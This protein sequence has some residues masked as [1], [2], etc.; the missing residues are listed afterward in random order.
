MQLGTLSRPNGDVRVA[1]KKPKEDGNEL[2]KSLL[3][4]EMNI[5]AHLQEG[6]PH[7]NILKMIGYITTSSEHFCLLTEYCELGSLDKFLRKKIESNKFEDEIAFEE[8]DSILQSI[9]QTYRV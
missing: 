5:M 1:I 9:K 8:H 7:E 3:R 6:L 4:E 2:Q